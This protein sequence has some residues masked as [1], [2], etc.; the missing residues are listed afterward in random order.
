[1]NEAFNNNYILFFEHD[2]HM[3]AALYINRKRNKEE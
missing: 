1:L 3:N 2:A